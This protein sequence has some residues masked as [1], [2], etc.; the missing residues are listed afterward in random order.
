[1]RG[2]IAVLGKHGRLGGA[3]CRGLS[4]KF[5]VVA[6]GRQEVD[7]T[8]AINRQ[9]RPFDFDLVINS[10]AATN[11]DWCERN[12]QAAERINAQAVE[13]IGMLCSERGVRCLHISTDYVFDGTASTP[14]QEDQATNPI[15]VYG[16]TKQLGEKLLLQSGERHLVIRVSWV[17]GPDKPS[18]IDMLL[19]RAT[20]E[21]RVEAIEDKYSA[22]TYSAD[23]AEW[24]EPLL[25][26]FPIGGILH[27]CNAGGC[28]WREFGQS[29]IDAALE[30][31]Q[32]LQARHVEPISLKSMTSFVAR[33]PAYSVMDQRRYR[34]L[35][36]VSPRPWSE[37]VRSYV[38]TK[39]C[40]PR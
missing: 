28:S 7:L 18:F 8:K 13:E 38:R 10:S 25:F 33:R 21:K 5:E 36:G 3:V 2:R 34:D 27:L 15:S 6:L 17:F 20:N 30:L 24:I 22:P 14:Y 35:T 37:A 32:Q 23:F 9:L 40:R 4:R 29:A 31:G 12:S 1:M 39:Y 26:D 19:E 16:K 11:L